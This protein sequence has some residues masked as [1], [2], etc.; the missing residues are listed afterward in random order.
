MMFGPIV[1]TE[2]ITPR[3]LFIEVYGVT[4]LISLHFIE[5]FVL[6]KQDL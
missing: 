1:L 4:L 2:D 5:S 3:A 6:V